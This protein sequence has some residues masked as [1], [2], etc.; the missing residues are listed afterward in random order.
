MAEDLKFKLVYFPF[1][2]RAGAI[3]DTFDVAKVF[4]GKKGIHLHL[5]PPRAPDPSNIF[6]SPPARVRSPPVASLTS[7][8]QIPYVNETL[9]RDDFMAKKE[10][11]PLGGLPILEITDKTGK[12]VVHTQSNAI[13]RY[14]GQLAGLYPK[15]LLD[16]LA[17]DEL[18]AICEE[19]MALLRPSLKEQDA[20]K[21]MEMRRAL[22]TDNL[23]K[24]LSRV[25]TMLADHGTECQH[26]VSDSLTI[27]DLKVKQIIDMIFS[28]QVEGITKV[29]VEPHPSILAWH[30]HITEHVT[31][32]KK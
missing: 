12:T 25:A 17:V 1:P 2:G 22:A 19:V 4:S 20:E 5:Q 18:L 24:I 15:D 11:L 7:L 27:A 23:P 14:V 21:R 16:A 31:E 10:T 9:T 28:G 29:L 32:R 26:I 13:L 6:T 8:S 3:R 30:K